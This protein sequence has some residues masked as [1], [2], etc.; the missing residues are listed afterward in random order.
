MAQDSDCACV[1]VSH[2]IR[3]LPLPVLLLPGS[4]LSGALCP[5]IY[6]V[7]LPLSL[8][9]PPVPQ[10]FPPCSLPTLL[11][12]SRLSLASPSCQVP[13]APRPRWLLYLPGISW[14][15]ELQVQVKNSCLEVIWVCILQATHWL[16][17]LNSDL[18]PASLIYLIHTMGI[19]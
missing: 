13:G 11:Q 4:C 3:S 17:R 1:P 8:S 7:P 9:V 16:Y 6:C 12:P 14:S 5:H 19:R 15:E 2:V 10:H 18:N